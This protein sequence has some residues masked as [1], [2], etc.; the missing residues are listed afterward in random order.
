MHFWS[1]LV[2]DPK[3][4]N[5]SDKE[6]IIGA[7]RLRLSGDANDQ[8]NSWTGTEQGFNFRESSLHLRLDLWKKTEFTKPRKT[9]CSWGVIAAQKW[10]QFSTLQNVI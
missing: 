5:H 6:T 1:I 4:K 9:F 10:G 8:Q 2:M 7:N 3:S